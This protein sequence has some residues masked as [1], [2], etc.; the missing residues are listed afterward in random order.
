MIKK[1]ATK[2]IRKPASESKVHEK[3]VKI[4]I[5]QD[6]SPDLNALDYAI[7]G[8]LE[9][10]INATSQSDIGSFKTT[11]DEEWNK[12]CEEFSLKA[13]ESFLKVCW[14]NNW[15]KNGGHIE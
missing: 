9:N 13:S 5:K 4:A 7:W 6:L 11:I 12:I 15:K 8:V 3:T 1:D 2:S 14:L 10:L